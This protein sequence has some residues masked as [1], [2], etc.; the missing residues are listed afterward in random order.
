MTSA[1][2]DPD[3]AGVRVLRVLMAGGGTAG[4]TASLLAT[5]E[6]LQW[7]APGTSVTS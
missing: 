3:R 5:A 7:F 1:P 6:S 2:S 4:H